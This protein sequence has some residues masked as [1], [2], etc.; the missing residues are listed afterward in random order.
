M[1][2]KRSLRSH[3]IVRTDW[4]RLNQMRAIILAAGKGSRLD[5]AFGEAV[6][7]LVKLGGMSLIERQIGCL[8]SAAIDDITVVVGFQAERVR[9]TCG[10]EIRF[11]ENTIFAETNSLYSL[12]L[13]REFI[14][15]GFVVMNSDVLFHPQLLSDLLNASYEDALLVS[16]RDD[17]IYGD[18]EMKVKIRGGQ[19]VDI[20]KTMKPDEADGENL[21]IAKFGKKGAAILGEKIDG[22]I[23]EG[24]LQSWAPRAFLEFARARPLHAVA[25]R[26]L[27]W[28][29]ID[30]A[31]DYR[32]AK[33]H[34]LPL[35]PQASAAP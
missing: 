20:S 23:A 19:L 8:R 32:R 18:E 7:C 21:G 28:I 24:A 31:E 22:L 1:D 25:T 35:F 17:T 9:K 2:G 4:G 6:K 29:E 34:I 33:E 16:L 30:F 14:S 26:G 11:I 12:W 27:P 10:P 5:S 3:E 13:A 15:A